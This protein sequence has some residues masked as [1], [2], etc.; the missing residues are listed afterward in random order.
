[1]AEGGSQPIQPILYAQAS[2]LDYLFFPGFTRISAALQ[3]YLTFDLSV[4]I[5]LLCTFGLL[6]FMC[7]HAYEHLWEWLE[8]YLS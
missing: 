6:A 8:T 7:K 1:M 4:Y 2:I 5:P 3:Q